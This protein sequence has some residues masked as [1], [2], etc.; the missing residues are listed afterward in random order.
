[1]A[2]EQERG[3]PVDQRADIFAIGAMLWELCALQRVP[4]VDMR[5]R[6]RMLR[7]GGIDRDLITIIDKTLDPDPRRRYSDAGA[8]AADLKAFKTGE[9]IAAR[10]YSLLALLSHWSRR[11]RTLAMVLLVA[12]VFTAVGATLYVKAIAAERDRADGALAAEALQKRKAIIAQASSL[13]ERDPTRAAAALGGLGALQAQPDT[14]V[15]RARIA[16]AGVADA[17]LSLPARIAQIELTPSGEQLIVATKERALYIIDLDTRIMRKIGDGLTEPSVVAAT[18]DDVYFVEK[19]SVLQLTKVAVKSGARTE[20]AILDGLPIDVQARDVD[21]VWLT[22]NGTLFE[23]T[24]GHSERLLAR[25]VSQFVLSKDEIA[26]CEKSQNLIIGAFDR[27]NRSM[28]RCIETWSW[29]QAS[30]YMAFQIDLNRVG[31][32]RDHVIRYYDLEQNPNAPI[33]LSE[34]RLIAAISKAGEG[35]FLPP[36][37]AAFHHVQFEQR[38]TSVDARETFAAWGFPDG[39]AT[40]LDTESGREVT[41]KTHAQHAYC[42]RL[43]PGHRLLTCGESEIRLWTLRAGDSSMIAE[44]PFRAFNIVFDQHKNALFD[45]AGGKVYMLEYGVAAP[46]SLHQHGSVAYSVAW[47]GSRACSASWDGKVLCSRSDG[48][49]VKTLV[50]LNAPIRWLSGNMNRCFAASSEGGV[51]DIDNSA[52]PVYRHRHEP[53]R[54]AV[55]DDGKFVAS[56]DW[57]GD[58]IIWSIGE[59]RVVADYPG[60]HSGRIMDL[61]WLDDR[62]ITAGIDGRVRMFDSSFHESDSWDLHSPIRYMSAAKGIVATAS[63]DGYVSRIV[64]NSKSIQRVQLEVI[65]TA[66]AFSA[67]ARLVAIATDDGDVLTTDALGHIRVSTFDRGIITGIAFEDPCT[68]LVNGARGRV[69]RTNLNSL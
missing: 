41:I 48:S 18:N 69:F 53:Y 4:P 60:L 67:D 17:V 51:Y 29:S 61:A 15:L 36:D 7:R 62:L 6:H 66:F 24:P 64:L 16:A 68:L 56:S 22:E 28:G 63:E 35:A 11:H 19:S 12:V 46:K 45:S 3:E 5:Q 14:A 58:L 57:G 52:Q 30:E 31:I 32:Y 40:I 47:C 13:L 23:Q 27:V 49:N 26:I 25:N 42:I 44:L 20:V 37:E 34:T 59:K 9:R 38:P 2:P 1:M 21:V 8:L 54:V 55:S 65:A 10:S 39:S 33:A 50:D 43:L